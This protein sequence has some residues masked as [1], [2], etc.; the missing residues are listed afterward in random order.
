MIRLGLCCKFIKEPIT[1]R[2]ATVTYLNKLKKE[3]KDHLAYLENIILHNISSLEK[4]LDYCIANKIGCFRVGS[5]FLPCITHPDTRYTLEDFNQSVE[6]LGGLQKCKEKAHKNDIRLVMHPSQF[7]LLSSPSEDVTR[8]SI[9]DLKYHAYLLELIGGDVINIHTGGAYGDKPAALARVKENFQKLP[10]KITSRLTLENDDKTYSPEEVAPLCKELGIPFV[11]DVHHHKCYS[12]SWSI[13]KATQEAL[14]T[15]N[16]EPLFHISSP[17]DG[18]QGP[19]PN[20]HHDMIDPNDFPECWESI[21]N[22]TLE[23]EAKA[24]EVAVL[25]FRKFLSDKLPS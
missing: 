20:R 19:K 8:K 9:E 3:G 10:P 22:F 25:A 24:K 14:S 16:R 21:P 2:T 4:A 5:D 15:W 6:M 18:W 11:Y 1:F 13:E 7:I 17:I 12:D 23:I